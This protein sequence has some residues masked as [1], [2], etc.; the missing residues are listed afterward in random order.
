MNI[1]NVSKREVL[2]FPQF[3][4]K[5]HDDKFDPY[6]EENQKAQ[7]EKTGLSAIKREPAYDHVG[8]ADAVFAHK[9]GINVPAIRLDLSKGIGDAF[10]PGS[11]SANT[12]TQTNESEKKSFVLKLNEFN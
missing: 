2:D 4:K 1:N 7:P 12:L 5:V 11:V 9:S 6:S 3:L 8:Y 10:S